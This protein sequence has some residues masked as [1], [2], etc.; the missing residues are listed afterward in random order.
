MAHQV[1]LRLNGQPLSCAFDRRKQGVL[2]ALCSGDGPAFKDT[3][4]G[5]GHTFWTAYPVELAEDLDAAANV[6]RY[7]LNCVGVNAP[8]EMTTNPSPCVMFVQPFCRMRFFM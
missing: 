5:K 8:F 4:Q 6:Y 7:V 2:E 1:E 3:T